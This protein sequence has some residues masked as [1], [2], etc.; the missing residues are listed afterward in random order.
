MRAT[1][2]WGGEMKQGA[3]FGL[4][5]G[6]R[7]LLTAVTGSV[8]VAIYAF[9]IPEDVASATLE[10]LLYPDQRHCKMASWANITVIPSMLAFNVN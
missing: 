3:A 10:R 7:G 9:L 8:M 6:G 2:E 5:D 4:L 1:R